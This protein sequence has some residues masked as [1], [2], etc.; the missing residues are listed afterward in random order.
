MGYNIVKY[1]PTFIAGGGKKFCP[2]LIIRNK[3][4]YRLTGMAQFLK[5]AMYYGCYKNNRLDRLDGYIDIR[6]K[7]FKNEILISRSAYKSGYV[8]FSPLLSVRV[9]ESSQLFLSRV[10]RWAGGFD[11]YLA[12]Y[13]RAE[14]KAGADE[15]IKNFISE[16]GYSEGS[17]PRLISRINNDILTPEEKFLLRVSAD[18]DKKKLI[19]DIKIAAEEAKYLKRY[20]KYA[21]ER[22]GYENGGIQFEK[23]F[24]LGLVRA[25]QKYYKD[26][27][28]WPYLKNEYGVQLIAATQKNI[29]DR[30]L[31]IMRKYGKLPEIIKENDYVQNICMHAFVC[32]KCAD[33]LFDYIY[34]F[35]FKDLNRSIDNLKD[36]EGHDLFD[37]LVEEIKSNDTK[38]VPNVMKHTTMA[39]KANQAG[40]KIRLRNILKMIDA[41]YWK[42][43]DYS[44]SENRLTKLFCQ[45]LEKKKAEDKN[46]YSGR[47]SGK[48][49]SRTSR[50]TLALGRGGKLSAVL[51]RQWLDISSNRACWQIDT[52]RERP[53]IYEAP[54][55]QGILPKRHTEEIIRN[56][57]IE[58]IL[59]A[60]DIQLVVDGR[61]ASRR[62]IPRREF[63]FFYK[64]GYYCEFSAATKFI[65]ADVDTVRVKSGEK[66]ECF[67]AEHMRP[68]YSLAGADFYRLD[69]R[70]GD[71]IIL[72]G[73]RAVAVGSE[74]KEGVVGSAP[75]S[76]TKAMYQGRESAVHTKA[77]ML[78]FRADRKHFNGTAVTLAD[79]SGKEKFSRVSPGDCMEFR[80]ADSGKDVYG[81]ALMLDRLIKQDGFYT[82][83][84]DV[85]GRDKKI[86]NICY[87]KDFDFSFTGAPYIFENMG[88]VQFPARLNFEKDEGWQTKD[89]YSTLDFNFEEGRDK[90][91]VEN[92]ALVL[93]YIFEGKKVDISIDLPVFYW[94][95]GKDDS[96][97]YEKPA[98]ISLSAL[99]SRIYITG[100]VKPADCFVSL[101]A[102]QDV[103]ISPQRQKVPNGEQFYF[104]TVDFSQYIDETD[105]QPVQK[106]YITAGGKK[107]EFIDIRCRGEVRGGRL[108]ADFGRGMVYGEF[109]ILGDG[110]YTAKLSRQDWVSDDL[111]VE[112]GKFYSG[113]PLGTGNCTVE[114]IQTTGDDLFSQDITIYKKDFPLVDYSRLDGAGLCITGIRKRGGEVSALPL[115]GVYMIRDLVGVPVSRLDGYDLYLWADEFGNIDGG[116]SVYLGEM[117]LITYKF[118]SMGRV[119]LI[120]SPDGQLRINVPDSDG[121][122]SNLIYRTDRRWL[123]TDE[124]KLTAKERKT[125]RVAIDDDLYE[126]LTEIRR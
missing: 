106:L 33:K 35:W 28:F 19:G 123:E 85:P 41:A 32:D 44:S 38:N 14:D 42:S 26:N 22:V 121:Y 49:G 65:S 48:K 37:D 104:R 47:T 102:E 105:E 97:H 24:A 115:S 87:I 60:F 122:C 101:R 62:R 16:N 13:D 116:F 6:I 5:I 7:S 120:F 3:K 93:P 126:I 103:D 108:R 79:I 77:G 119:L 82:V 88:S 53:L 91:Y 64:N 39:V 92:H 63:R 112:D 21:L 67:P 70:E 78:Y 25:A 54:L 34:V 15:R 81:Y 86:Y 27:K 94:N 75:A 45:W 12:V 71:V 76:G 56:M 110:Q 114:I 84:V 9:I 124:S 46:F 74:M 57:E 66:I 98:E 2:A 4:A 100:A 125:S 80:I 30:F 113:Y 20:M 31:N 95:F 58:N 73:G 43:A 90:N 89:G 83:T 99:P 96:W 61:W 50:P 117:G 52:G 29:G 8:K 111:P 17:T 36:E 68:L 51:P 69:C 107:K 11:M 59:S 55:Y 1:T 18:F 23:V 118:R 10:S 109:D 40:C 72:P